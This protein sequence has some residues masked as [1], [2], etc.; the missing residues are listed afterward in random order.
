MPPIRVAEVFAALSLT[1]DLAS[2]V[3]V[4]K[5]LRTC[6]VAT[7]FAG[8]LGMDATERAAVFHASL[9]RSVGCTSYASENAALFVDDTAFQA[10]LKRLDPGDPAVFGAQ[11]AEFG[12]WA[13]PDRQPALAARFAD[14]A[15]TEGPRA[16][17]TGCE[18]SRA[19]GGR[20]GLPPAAVTALDDVYERWD[21]LGIPDGRSGEELS[22][23]GRVVHVAE[24]AVFAHASG[25]RA[26]AVAEVT[27]RAG[28]HLDPDLAARFVA[29]ADEV[30]AALDA[31]DLLMAVV[32]AEPGPG[33]TVAA[34]GLEELCAALAVVVDLKGLH[35]AGHSGHVA[36]VAG[37]AAGLAGMPDGER[38]ALRAAALLHDL[39]RAAVSSA[40]WDRAGPLGACGLGAGAAARLLDRPG[41]APVPGPRPARRGRGRAPR[42]LR[43]QRVPPRGPGG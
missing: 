37:A 32:A 42:A 13:G 5:G 7:A 6:V 40:I 36:D 9:L 2:G 10:A 21:G 30:L 25:G 39:G 12:G 26:A 18:V 28:G 15:A 22:A 20:L 43:R 34:G 4:E 19:L 33:A 3:P 31:P 8:V 41:P 27:R 16:A 29:D 14:I 23:A 38:S 24:Q 1:T 11:L 35:L 17:R